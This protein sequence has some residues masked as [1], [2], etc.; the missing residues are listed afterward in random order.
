MKNLQ[1][2]ESPRL[3]TGQAFN[4]PLQSVEETKGTSISFNAQKNVWIKTG[5]AG[6]IM[7]EAGVYMYASKNGIQDLLPDWRLNSSGTT[8]AL[9]IQP[10]NGICFSDL[11]PENQ[12]AALPAIC[13]ALN[14]LHDANI[15]H[16][17][18]QPDHIFYDQRTERVQF[19][20]LGLAIVKDDLAL[21]F[22]HHQQ[23]TNPHTYSK[24]NISS[25][26]IQIS[27]GLLYKTALILNSIC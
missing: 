26:S 9:H 2:Q 27:N 8:P 14:R 21:G 5:L 25:C 12:K 1:T 11:L 18:L 24:P 17:D 10:A 7:H 23:C 22:S 4:S 20:D 16:G 13:N 3:S 19:I 15:Y 6:A